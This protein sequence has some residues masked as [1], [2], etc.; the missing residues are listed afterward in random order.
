MPYDVTTRTSAILLSVVFLCGGCAS[1]ISEE[2]TTAVPK[3]ESFRELSS[4]EMKQK[5]ESAT[6]PGMSAEGRMMTEKVMMAMYQS[7][8]L[9]EQFFGAAGDARKKL[10][11][12]ENASVVRDVSYDIV[13]TVDLNPRMKAPPEGKQMD[14]EW[15]IEQVQGAYDGLFLVRPADGKP[16]EQYR[17]AFEVDDGGN[18]HIGK[19]EKRPVE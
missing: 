17:M 11:G 10:A 1:T 9:A 16:L 7:K 12:A 8:L 18:R 6:L 3:V 4:T 14:M 19:V 15:A 13:E 2:P 5:M